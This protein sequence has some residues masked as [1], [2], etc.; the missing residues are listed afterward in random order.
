MPDSAGLKPLE[1]DIVLI[2]DTYHHIENRIEYLKKLKNA[3]RKGGM[4][5][6]IDFKK[7]ETPVGPPVEMRIA[8]EQV[9]SELKAAGYTVVSADSE[10]LPYQYL[11]QAR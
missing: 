9:Q 7:E 5:V 4:L 10:T 8:D 1:A 2:V 3:F 11:I 6:I